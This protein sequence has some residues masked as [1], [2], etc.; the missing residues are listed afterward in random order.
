[1]VSLNR[2]RN[3]ILNRIPGKIFFLF[4]LFSISS[5]AQYSNE[6]ITFGQ[7]YYRIPIAKDGIYKLSYADLQ[8]AGVPVGAVDPRRIQLYHRGVEQAVFMQGQSDAKL[9]PGD[10]MEFYGKRNDG[11]LDANL[12]QPSLAQPH[13]YYNLYSDTTAY[14]LTWNQLPVQGKRMSSFSEVNVTGIP[15]E[16]YHT[17]RK[18]TVYANEYSGGH[19]LGGVLQYTF[20]DEGEGWTGAT[21]CIGNSGCTGLQNFVIDNLINGVPSAGNPKLEL[22]L[23]GRDELLHQA[24]VYVGAN[25]GSLRLLS[26]SN[27]S[28][29]QTSL[30][31]SDIN[32]SD[33][34]GDGRMTVQVKALGVNGIRDRLSLSYIKVS[35]P[36]NFD[37]ASQVEKTLELK[38]NPSNKS[39]VEI[40]NPVAGLRV[41]DITDSN[42]V[43]T[44]GTSPSGAALS[45]VV[46][47]T[48]DSR[49]LFVGNSSITPSL[50]LV[51]FRQINPASHNYLIVTHR[52]LMKPD[53]VQAYATYRAST[54]G[55]GYDTLTVAIDQLYNQFNFGETSPRGIYQFVKYMVENG[56]PQYLFLIG[57]GRDV[58]SG[59][60]RFTTIPSTEFRDLVPT[61]GSPASDMAFSAGL[62]GSGFGPS[63]ATGRLSASTPTHVATYLNKIK[64]MESAPL[65][66]LWRK[67]ALHLSGGIQPSELINFRQYMDGFKATAE[68]IYWGG[69]VTTIGKRDPSPV[70]LISISDQIN[71]GLN[72]VTFFGHSSPG[73][74]DLDIG[75]VSNPILGYENP[76]K[77]PVFLIN[78]CNAGNFFS[79]GISFGED[80]MLTADKGA[81]GFIAHSSF[82]FVNTLR[83]YTDLFYRIGFGDS[84]FIQKGI[85]D[86]QKEVARQYLA[87]F[88]DDISAVTQTQQMVLLA[89]PAIKLFGTSKPDYE[90]N[91]DAISMKSL[92]GK[93][94]TASSELFA[95]HINVRNFGAAKSGQLPVRIIRT[96]NDNSKITY[97]SLFTSVF[98]EDTLIFKIKKSISGG[99][100]TN[101]FEVT[102]DPEGKIKELNESNNS[103]I[104]S[105]FIPLNGT[106]NL[107]PLPYGIE[108][109]R[110]S[111][112]E[113]V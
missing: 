74:I 63:L 92:D 107:F 5:H 85:G 28:N 24:Q 87:S 112:R 71:K 4:F 93:P 67:E 59:F 75:Y 31:S 105:A 48:I 103:G 9:D 50:K 43:L 44:I 111:C 54:E 72:M 104:L 61:A 113:R 62:Q 91:G 58:S 108:I 13:P 51:A 15:K 53:A 52:S 32:W 45:A 109:G 10:F 3:S 90:T 38:P 18:L 11:A 95:I 40:D 106:K 66:E 21:I 1:M 88:G 65:S 101:Q 60:H 79:N 68:D 29:F 89:D 69:K 80:W 102:I 56:S 97:D 34:G 98:F 96:L 42:N 82:G 25:S 86:V 14:F 16:A 46:P 49:I 100:G 2:K 6:W 94:V 57:K 70:E 26:T 33:I 39:Y 81:R 99:F 19:T 83:S 17:D 78:G 77:Y 37:L 55:G 23:V 73:T 12:Y 110:A 35:L 41:W 64:E 84:T 27:F 22:M 47:S 76:G 20:F 8:A 7:Q 30:I 36:Q